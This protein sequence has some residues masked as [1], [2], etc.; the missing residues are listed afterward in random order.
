MPAAF[1]DAAIAEL[2]TRSDFSMI[3]IGGYM[4]AKRCRLVLVNEE[5]QRFVELDQYAKVIKILARPGLGGFSEHLPNVLD[6]IGI[7]LTQVGDISL[8]AGEEGEEL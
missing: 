6:N 4:N 8:V 1:V 3:K 2:G 5:M 7:P